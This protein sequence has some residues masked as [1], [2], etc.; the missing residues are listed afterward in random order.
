MEIKT[1]VVALAALAQETRLAVFRLLIEAGPE[2]MP[3]GA[4]GEKLEVPAATLSFHLK[5][6]S[7]GA[8]ITARQDGRFIYYAV[9]FE[10]MAALM[11]FLTQNCCRGM[12]QECLT[13]V[14]TALGRCCAGPRS[15]PKSARSRS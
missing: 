11:S 14:E 9:D 6:L 13:V 3:P 2:G 7:Q 12:P 10:R 1:A 8:L 15:K 5:A 4:I